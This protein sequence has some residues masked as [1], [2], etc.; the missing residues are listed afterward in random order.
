VDRK[1]WDSDPE[2]PVAQALLKAYALDCSTS[3]NRF[4][5]I[6]PTTADAVREELGDA[7]FV[8]EAANAKWVWVNY[9]DVMWW[10]TILLREWLRQRKL[11]QFAQ[12]SG[13]EKEDA[14]RVQFAWIALCASDENAFNEFGRDAG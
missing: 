5:R 6:S 7:G 4:G 11:Q 2:S 8:L 3:A 14:P 13:S 12:I 10:P 9:W 1:P